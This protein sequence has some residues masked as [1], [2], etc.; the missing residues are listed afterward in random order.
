MKAVLSNRIYME[1][2]SS[3]QSYIDKELTYSI[4]PRRPT[5]PPIFIKNMGVIRAG[6]VSLPI[7]RTDLIPEDYEIVDKR[8]DISI[9]PL[10]FKFTLRDSQQ[11]VYDEVFDSCIINAWVSWGK[12]FTALAIANKLQQK[13]LIVTHTLTLRA[14][15]EKEIQKVF[16]VAAGVI[17][18]G[19]FETDS[20]FVV[21]NVQTLY[22]NIDKITKEF[23]TLILDEMHHV[24]S[25]TFTRIVDASRARYKIGLTGTMQR[26]DGRHVIFRD[27]FSDKVLKPPK[28]NYLTPRVD[29]VKSGIRFIDGNVDW[30]SRVNALA[31]NWEYQNMIALLAAN[32]AARGHKVLVVSDR[33]DFL[34]SCARLVGDNAIC[35]TG[36]IPHEE[37]PEII[38]G[39][40]EEKDILFGTQSIFSE[41][42]SLD[43]LSCL[44]L[45][46]PV[47]NEP[48]LTQLIGRIIRIYEGKLQPVIADI[49]LEGRTARK[50]ASAR[51]GYYM[52]QGYVVSDIGVK[53]S[54]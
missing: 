16:G 9:E 45:G 23:G 41:G 20:P 52:K 38:K 26:K 3:Y 35:V 32:Y 30:A 2:N 47:N 33:V 4:P 8:N 19:R 49:H 28:E 48:L 50:Q 46:T 53:N 12:T 22:R 10:D 40:F 24:S 11:A 27:Y 39:I 17:G 36:D 54:T 15:W 51:M 34:K 14:Q 5:D 18:S 21:G 31:Y 43:C 25:P 29:I 1:V 6:L 42:I 44:V 37:R 7:G 13:T